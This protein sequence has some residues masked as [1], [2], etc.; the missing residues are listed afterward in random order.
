MCSLDAERIE[1]C[2]TGE[3]CGIQTISLIDE[4]IV[5]P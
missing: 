3:G 4:N 2:I 1:K 5:D